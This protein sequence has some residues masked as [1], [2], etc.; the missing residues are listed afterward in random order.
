VELTNLAALE[1]IFA[2]P[3]FKKAKDVFHGLVTN[4]SDSLLVEVS[5]KKK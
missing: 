2:S 1:K 5:A 4:V 3:V